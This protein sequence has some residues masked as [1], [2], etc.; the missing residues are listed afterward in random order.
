MKIVLLSP[1]WFA[2][3]CSLVSGFREHVWE[4]K[5]PPPECRQP[6]SCSAG[7]EGMNLGIPLKETIVFSPSLGSPARLEQGFHSTQS[8]SPQHVPHMAGTM[9]HCA[10]TESSLQRVTFS[11]LWRFSAW[12]IFVHCLGSPMAELSVSKRFGPTARQRVDVQVANAPLEP[13]APKGGRE[14]PS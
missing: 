3:E 5:S 7:N 9:F 4:R 10:E 1:C 14:G 8:T 12:P 6:F 13:G 2:V 11:D